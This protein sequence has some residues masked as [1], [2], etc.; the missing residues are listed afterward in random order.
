MASLLD[1]PL[2]QSSALP[3]LLSLILAAASGFSSRSGAKLAAAAI[4]I[5]ILLTLLQIQGLSLMP[6]SASQKLPWLIAIACSAVSCW[7][8]STAEAVLTKSSVWCYP[9]PC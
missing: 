7:I 1:N 2:L 3:L 6:R 8:C 4:G 5:S 9:R